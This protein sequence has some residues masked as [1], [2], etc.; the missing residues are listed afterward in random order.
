MFIVIPLT[1]REYILSFL[2][3]LGV[4]RPSVTVMALS[5]MNGSTLWSIQLPEET[6]SV[7]CNGLSLGAAAGPVCLV[8][9][10]SK[11]LSLL[12]A[13]TGKVNYE[14]IRNMLLLFLFSLKD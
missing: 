10:T 6:Q 13:S 3:L 4:S 9:G 14:H 8:T 1:P 5:G 11:F 7:Q 12:S 2:P